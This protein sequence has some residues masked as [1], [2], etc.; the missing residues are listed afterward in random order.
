MNELF[1]KYK[2]RGNESNEK[3]ILI[4]NYGICPLCLERLL[5]S[6]GGYIGKNLIIEDVF[7]IICKECHKKIIHEKSYLEKVVKFINEMKKDLD[8][9]F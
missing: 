6:K 8:N 4:E 9:N 3:K 5:D 2:K 7:T 1:K